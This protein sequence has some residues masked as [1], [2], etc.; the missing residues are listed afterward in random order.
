MSAIQALKSACKPA[1]S[2]RNFCDIE[3]GVYNIEEFKFVQT[4]YGRKLVVRCEDFMCFLPDRCSKAIT[5]DQQIIE[6]NSGAWAL[7]YEGRDSRRGNLIMV[8]FIERPEWQFPELLALKP[9]DQ[10]DESV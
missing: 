9:M 4:V 1:A 10:Q 2:Y 8:D 3:I 7:K 6:L 5:T